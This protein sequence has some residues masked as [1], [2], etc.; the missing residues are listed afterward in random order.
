LIQT[1]SADERSI[2]KEAV[3]LCPQHA[4]AWNNLGTNFEK[5]GNWEQAEKA[6]RLANEYNPELGIPLAGLGDVSVNQGR[7]QEAIKW[8]QAFLTFLAN[9]KQK[10][11][12]QGLGIYEKEYREKQYRANLK[13]KILTDSMSSVVPKETIMRGLK[14][15]SPK[16]EFEKRI[17]TERLSLLIY[18]NFDSAELK[19]QGQAQ[20]IELAQTMLSPEH[21]DRVFLIEGHSDTLGPDEYNLDLSQ[22]RAAKVREFLASQGVMSDRLRVKGVGE[23]KPFISTGGKDE[24]AINRRVEFVRLGVYGK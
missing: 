12:P 5:E 4:E 20:L 9:E 16:D 3:S 8:Y 2:L 10:G 17:E 7:Y 15:I 23:S 11:D 14:P 24:Q 19:P 13:L 1:N 18:F 21:R 22:R 6:Y